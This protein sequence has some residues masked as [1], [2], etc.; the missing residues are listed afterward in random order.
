MNKLVIIGASGHGKVVADIARLNGYEDI[1]FLDDALDLTM[2]SGYWVAGPVSSFPKFA[3]CDFVIAIGDAEVR[4]RIQ[5]QLQSVGISIIT[6]VHPSA[7]VAGNVRIG[8]GSVVMAGS[9]INPFASI[10]EG[11]IV[12]TGATIDHDCKVGDYVHVSVGA[13]LAGAVTVGNGTWIGI[14]AV[15]SNNLSICPSCII[16]AGAVVVKDVVAAGTYVGVPAEKLFIQIDNK[17]SNG[18]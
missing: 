13:H 4:R 7:V 18:A 10:G 17:E 3:D 2:V 12:N 1:V 11:C 14:G 6:L 16:G 9:V 8:A 15:V 5:S